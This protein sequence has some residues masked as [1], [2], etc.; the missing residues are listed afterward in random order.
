MLVVLFVCSCGGEA[1]VPK[2]VQLSECFYSYNY[3]IDWSAL[4]EPNNNPILHACLSGAT[5]E[6]MHSLHI[7]DIDERIKRLEKGRIIKRIDDL[8]VAAHPVV[9]GGKRL[10]LNLV[11]RR[12]AAK[13][14]PATKNTVGKIRPYLKGRE[15]MLYH[16]MWSG[17]M[18]GGL[19]WQTLKEQLG[20]QLGIDDINLR[21]GWW[22]YPE[23]SH[24]AGTNTYGSA[25]G[26]LVITGLKDF[27]EPHI[28]RK[29]M[30]GTEHDL[31][32]SSL[33]GTPVDK[34]KVNKSLRRYGLIDEKGHSRLFI[35][36]KEDPI[37]PVASKLSVEF[38]EGAT[39]HLDI[40]QI[41]R[42]LDTTPEQSLVIWYHELC[43]ELLKE[44]T[45]AGVLDLPKAADTKEKGIRRLV[46]FYL[47]NPPREAEPGEPNI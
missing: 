22:I 46:S 28:I 29:V 38:A 24:R 21:M 43:Y 42:M 15:D 36:K 32:Q 4:R 25:Q 34:E 10:E 5:K 35:L 1:K 30:Q 23:H 13:I 33:A 37:V 16:V 12:A 41:A 26:M 3:V 47:L 2:S 18:D 19:A 11:I 27:P 31:I 6:K 45:I 9:V 44:L 14:L 40:E 39:R 8:Y 20:R 7:S 17:I